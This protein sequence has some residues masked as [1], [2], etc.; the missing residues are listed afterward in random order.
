[1][2]HKLVK[3]LAIVEH[4]SFIHAA[5]HLHVSQPALTAAIQ[6]LEKELRVQLLVRQ[7]RQCTL[8]PAGEAVYA[9]AVRMRID[10]NALMQQVGSAT[11]SHP[12]IRIG[13]LDT[14]ASGLMGLLEEQL[15]EQRMEIAVDNSSRLI[16]DV[17][18]GRLELAI[19]VEQQMALPDGITHTVLADEQFMFVATPLVAAAQQPGVVRNWL[20]FNPDSTTYAH[21]RREFI[22]SNVQVQPIFYSTSM[23]LLKE[24]CV[25]GLGVALLPRQLVRTE[26]TQGVLVTVGDTT[27]A[28]RLWLIRQH[29]TKG[30]Q[31]E[32]AIAAIT[33]AWAAH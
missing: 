25:R 22:H 13:M 8:T 24:L 17:R 31:G 28:R 29:T 27:W 6:Q 2:D 9:G 26:L 23:E 1:M 21:F 11:Q 14:V 7:K 4:K 32:Q 20:A 33:A 19:I 10:Y 18:A 30:P 5:R 12:S 16:N 15:G 3:F